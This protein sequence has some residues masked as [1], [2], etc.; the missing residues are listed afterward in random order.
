MQPLRTRIAIC[1]TAR[2]ARPQHPYSC[3]LCLARLRYCLL[4]C[5]AGHPLLR[6]PFCLVGSRNSHHCCHSLLACGGQWCL[7]S[8]AL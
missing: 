7:P 8:M 3:R 2:S 1:Y 6:A 4:Y 5:L